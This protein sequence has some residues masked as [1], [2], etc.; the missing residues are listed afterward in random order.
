MIRLILLILNLSL[1]VFN[2]D[3]KWSCLTLTGTWRCALG[4][5]S[6]TS[7]GGGKPVARY[8]R[9]HLSFGSGPAVRLFT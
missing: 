9:R 7:S 1:V 5:G 4:S 6:I 3:S 8:V 2:A